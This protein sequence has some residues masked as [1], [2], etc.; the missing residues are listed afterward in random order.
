VADHP[1]VEL[2]RRGYTAFQTGDLDAVRELFAPDIKWHTPGSG[3]F[4]GTRNGVDDTIA[5][6]LQ[7]FEESGGTFKVEV[8]DIL[9]NDEHAVALG[10]ASAEKDGRSIRDNYTHVV[11]LSGGRVTESWI[12]D[13]DPQAVD[14][15]WG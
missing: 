11:H 13:E 12:F 6:F 4:S 15:F 7:Q 10:T 9:A 2:F 14:E 3:K 1:N 8:H 5:L